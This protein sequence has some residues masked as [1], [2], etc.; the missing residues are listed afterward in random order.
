MHAIM[1]KLLKARK[2]TKEEKEEDQR[3]QGLR[4]ALFGEKL[5][6]EL[7]ITETMEASEK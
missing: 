3:P 4:E 7:T 5:Q 1:A 6:H 2:Q